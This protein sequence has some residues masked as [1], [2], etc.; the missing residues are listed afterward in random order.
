MPF[1]FPVLEW[2]TERVKVLKGLQREIVAFLA[3]RTT[4]SVTVR[5]NDPS[6]D[7][8]PAAPAKPCPPAK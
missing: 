4:G 8:K 5:L 1:T 2:Q 3:G 6:Q 7:P